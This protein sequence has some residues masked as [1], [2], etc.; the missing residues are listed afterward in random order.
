MSITGLQNDDVCLINELPE[1]KQTLLGRKII[2][3]FRCLKFVNDTFGKPRLL[4]INCAILLRQDKVTRTRAF[5]A[6]TILFFLKKNR[7]I[8]C[9]FVKRECK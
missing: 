1:S 2:M 3:I 6:I 7:F 4:G 8:V 9:R 5:F